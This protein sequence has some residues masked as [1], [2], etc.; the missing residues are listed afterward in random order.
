[1]VGIDTSPVV[2]EDI[3]MDVPHAQAVTIPADKATMSKDLWRAIGQR[4]LFQLHT[5]PIPTRPQVARV[6]PDADRVKQ[7]EAENQQLHERVRQLEAQVA[8]SSKLD[9]ILAAIQQGGVTVAAAPGRLV[10][11]AKEAL[12]G[13][14]EVDVPVF[15]PS[16]KSAD[17]SETRLGV[18]AEALRKMRR[19][20][21]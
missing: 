3:G 4:R 7:L 10:P 5:G 9:Q 12:P 6:S 20:G 2:L 15:I 1:V 16:V 21:R 17:V 8:D 11:S 18:Q 19:A 13:V 14:V